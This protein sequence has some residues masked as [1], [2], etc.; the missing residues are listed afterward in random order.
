M[1]L[2]GY[3]AAGAVSGMGQSIQQ[4]AQNVQTA[5]NQE[6]LLKERAK[7]EKE[8]DARQNEFQAGQTQIQEAGATQRHQETLGVKKE[9]HLANS[10]NR[11][12]MLEQAVKQTDLALEGLKQKGDERR[13][14]ADYHKQLLTANA[15][16][17][18]A[19]TK[20]RQAEEQWRHEERLAN[21]Q[22]RTADATYRTAAAEAAKVHYQALEKK[23]DAQTTLL[24]KQIELAIAKVGNEM[25]PRQKAMTEATLKQ[26][27]ASIATIKDV[28]ATEEEKRQAFGQLT[29]ST[30][31]INA[32]FGGQA[33]ATPTVGA[34]V[35]DP[36]ER[37]TPAPEPA[38]PT[39]K[40]EITPYTPGAVTI[41]KRPLM[42]AR[43]ERQVPPL[44]QSDVSQYMR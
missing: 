35:V 25:T 18:E 13:E 34:R 17:H 37:I 16:E 21:E 7:L 5:W 10:D 19:A 38:K 39:T 30:E 3:M 2:M 32:L 22:N 4:G 11:K 12:L 20:A 28:A 26:M 15:V 36:L 1:S 9:E 33:E 23:E 43:R 14:T 41:E 29:A 6:M 27:D 40:E 42:K 44:T 31:R 8:R 24:K